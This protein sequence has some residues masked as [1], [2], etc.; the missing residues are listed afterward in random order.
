MDWT[1][2]AEE[3]LRE[4][5]FFVRPAVRNRIERLAGEEGLRRID[6]PFYE[7]ARARFARR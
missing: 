4:V 2:E 6:V 7:Q 5:P 3:R 1:P